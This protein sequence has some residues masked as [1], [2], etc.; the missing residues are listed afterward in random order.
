MTTLRYYF[1]FI[2]PY[3]YLGWGQVKSLAQRRGV[4]L[5]P[6]PVLFAAMLD[7]YGHKGPAE[8]E[9][10]RIY[11][12]KH[13][14]RLAHDLGVPLR[15]PPAHPFKPLLA[16][17]IASLP[18]PRAEREAII[19]LLFDRTWAT[20]VGVTDPG[21]LVQALDAAGL[22]GTT[23]VQDASA[24]DNKARLRTQTTDAVQRGVFGVP[25]MEPDASGEIFWGQDAMPHL[26]RYLDGGDPVPDD[27]LER[28]RGL[29]QG[30]VRPSSKA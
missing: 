22:P 20:G 16:L 1:D 9:P 17:R 25:S 8:I 21:A 3:A 26:E 24:A 23:L 18:R 27:L 29:P 4:E 7:T 10:K 11:T 14:T 13:V 12:F 5:E 15:P 30:A 28:W 19:D 2:S 6:V